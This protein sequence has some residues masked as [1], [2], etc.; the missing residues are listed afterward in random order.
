MSSLSLHQV[1]LVL[2]CLLALVSASVLVSAADPT[3]QFVLFSDRD[4]SEKVQSQ[5]L[6]ANVNNFRDTCWAYPGSDSASYRLGAQGDNPAWNVSF[7]YYQSS[8]SCVAP[9]SYALRP[10]ESVATCTPAR[11]DVASR[12]YLTLYYTALCNTTSSDDAEQQQESQSKNSILRLLTAH[13]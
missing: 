6:A 11:L 12:L 4:C 1:V 5:T 10:S 3:C 7:T 9:L 2:C 13:L 8:T